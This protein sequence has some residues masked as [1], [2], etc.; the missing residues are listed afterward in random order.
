MKGYNPQFDFGFGLSYSNFTYSDFNLSK[1]ELN[2]NDSVIISVK[3][4]NSG[5]VKGQEVVQLFYHDLFASI[6]P[7][8]K[9]LCA[10][11]KITLEPSETTTVSFSL[12]KNDFS[13]INKEL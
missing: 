7:S 10:F 12:H 1:S 5:M 11:N 6:T 3:V 13:F 2:N 4:K 8:A 9:R